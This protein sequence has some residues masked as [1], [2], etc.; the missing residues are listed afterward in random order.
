M[1]I[2]NTYLLPDGSGGL[3]DWQLTCRGH[4]MHDVSYLITTSLSVEDRRANEQELVRF[5]LDR[6]AAEGVTAIPSF[7][8]SFTEFGRCLMWGVYIGWLTTPV[9]NYGWEINVMNHFRLT[10]AFEDH[11]TAQL[12]AEIS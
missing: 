12:I 9:V 6:L 4:H 5:Y 2:G 7:E 1:H 8:V 11:D 10:T 3:L